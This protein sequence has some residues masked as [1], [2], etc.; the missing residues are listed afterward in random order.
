[1]APLKADDTVDQTPLR[2]DIAVTALHL[3]RVQ[4]HP[5]RGAGSLTLT[6]EITASGHPTF[7][8]ATFG[9]ASCRQ[10]L[11]AAARTPPKPLSIRHLFDGSNCAWSIPVLVL[12]PSGGWKSAAHAPTSDSRARRRRPAKKICESLSL[13]ILPCNPER[14]WRE[15]DADACGYP[16]ALR[17][18]GAAVGTSKAPPPHSR[19]RVGTA[20]RPARPM[21]RGVVLFPAD[22]YAALPS[23]AASHSSNTKQELQTKSGEVVACHRS[24]RYRRPAPDGGTSPVAWE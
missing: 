12:P 18:G 19:R 10:A 11:H 24:R 3:A 9:A 1:M 8:G 23:L 2:R 17:D 22:C 14:S 4:Q 13:S 5:L 21:H 15:R 7:L 6:G 20:H 16:G